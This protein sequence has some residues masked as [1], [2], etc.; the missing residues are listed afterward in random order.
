MLEDKE[1]HE[2]VYESLCADRDLEDVGHVADHL[3]L[4]FEEPQKSDYLDHLDEL[5]NFSDFGKPRDL[6]NI[7]H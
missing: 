5:V 2:Q 6:I 4:D 1:C 3:V 7:R